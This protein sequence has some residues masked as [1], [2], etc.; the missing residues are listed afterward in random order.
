MN[1]VAD[2]FVYLIPITGTIAL[3]AFLA[4]NSWA[5]ARRKERESYYRYEFR[6]QLVDAGK[7]DV[8]DV[9]ELMQ[10]EQELEMNRMR[11]ANLIGGFV[12]IGVGVGL[13][14]GLSWIAEGIWMVGYIPLFI[15]I[16]LMIYALFVAPHTQP[17]RPASFER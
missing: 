1:W 7:M 9:R 17:K 14:F 4:V 6:N 16:M 2:A 11:Q 13:I 3:F 12:L 15:G 8:T 5:D 10:Y